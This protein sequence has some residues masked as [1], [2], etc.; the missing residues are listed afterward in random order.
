MKPNSFFLVE[1]Y[2][3]ETSLIHI[4]LEQTAPI[5]TK[6]IQE[7]TSE[8]VISQF[9]VSK[10]QNPSSLDPILKELCDA[11][12]RGVAIKVLIDQKLSAE[13]Q[14]TIDQIK[15]CP[16]TDLKTTSAF[17]GV[18]HAKYMIFDQKTLFLGSQNFD[19]R[20]LTHIQEL[21]VVLNNK[22]LV[23]QAH[24]I[25]YHDW[26]NAQNPTD[27]SLPH[28]QPS[29]I[30]STSI[31]LKISPTDSERPQDSEEYAL[32]SALNSAQQ[33]IQLQALSYATTDYDGAQ[34]LKIQQGLIFAL[35]RGVQ[36]QLII[37]EWSLKEHQLADLYQL[38]DKGAQIKWIE[39]PQHSSGPILYARVAHAKYGIVDNRVHWITT[40]NLSGDYYTNS[41]NLSFWWE[42][43]PL[44]QSLQLQKYFQQNWN[45]SYAKM[46]TKNE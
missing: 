29:T 15:Q 20:A 1:S 37:S 18:Q 4:G 44:E 43:S 26:T 24:D 5:W 17:K 46:L 34:W 40:S 8:I 14:Q 35:H 2:P 33:S 9:Y 12:H 21:G 11:G 19:D 23:G 38:I 13:Y 39:F 25:F 32:L 31:S 41:R 28:L 42:G 6:L 3:V 36:V 45:S 27:L 30:N 22:D 10:T 16:N 7:A